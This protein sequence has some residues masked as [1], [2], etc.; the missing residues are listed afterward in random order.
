M[1]PGRIPC[2]QDRH[3]C[4]RQIRQPQPGPSWEMRSPKTPKLVRFSRLRPVSS[5][6][7]PLSR[8]Q[9][10]LRARI[11]RISFNHASAHPRDPSLL[12][13]CRPAHWSF[14][15][16]PVLSLGL[17]VPSLS[18]WVSQ[19]PPP[20]YSP[21]DRPVRPSPLPRPPIALANVQGLPIP[22][23]G[24]QFLS[25]LPRA[26]QSPPLLRVPSRLLRV[27]ESPPSTS[28][29]PRECP[30]RPKP[31]PHPPSALAIA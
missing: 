11:A 5:I 7:S 25:R 16:I 17:P 15:G 12:H 2:V 23:L 9:P 26:S 3:S 29:F 27:S 8:L 24:L 21:R 18:P 6:P 19:F 31:L 28:H 14:P 22:S 1:R 10:S 20:S 4:L 30:G 13:A